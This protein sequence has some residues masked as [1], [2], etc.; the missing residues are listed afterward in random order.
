MMANSEAACAV[1]IH[2]SQLNIEDRR[3]TMPTILALTISLARGF[4]AGG[5]IDPALR[6]PAGRSTHSAILRLCP[7]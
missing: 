7:F 1:E 6:S 2:D 5:M 3:L 4:L